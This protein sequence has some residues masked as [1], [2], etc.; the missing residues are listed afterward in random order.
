[1][2]NNLPK[3][4][5]GLAISGGFIR[6]VSAI[7]VIEVLQEN[8]IQIDMV[9]GCSAGSG[10]A[11]A[12]AAGKLEIL[13]SRLTNGTRREYLHFIFDPTIPSQGMLK[14]ERG[15][16]FFVEIFGGDINFSDLPMPLYVAATDLNTMSPV[17]LTKGSVAQ[18][19][20]AAFS[21]PGM[22]VPVVYGDMILADGGNFNQ[23]PSAELYN[24]GADYVIAV[25]ATQPP[26]IATRTLSLIKKSLLPNRVPAVANGLAMSK[27]ASIVNIVARAA[28]LSSS[29]IENFYHHTYRYDVLIKPDVHGIKR[30]SIG[31]T[32]QLIKEGRQA[33][34]KALPQIKKDLGV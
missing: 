6:P 13:K 34:Y 20:R 21:L 16:D 31:K 7:G 24:Q 14:G 26:N 1:M 12:L 3:K 32:K 15:K 30:W 33:A 17:I 11:A 29:H 2:E 23:I 18:A 28:D 27:N 5:I 22:F 10:V 25:D 19:V 8:G 4:K 9:S